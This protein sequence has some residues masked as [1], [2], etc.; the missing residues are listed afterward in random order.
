M[1]SAVTVAVAA[2]ATVA[3]TGCATVDPHDAFADVQSLLA[4]REAA[5]V[6]W[7]LG[8]AADAEAA[9]KVAGLLDTELTA[10]AAV[11]IALLE[12]RRLQ[13]L[14]ERLGVAQ[15][16]LVASGLLR[17]PVF[18][19]EVRFAEGGGSTGFELAVLQPF[20]DVLY[21]PL[22]RRV[23]AA[24]LAA[25]KLRVSGAVLAFAADVR[26]SFYSLQAAL[27]LLELRQTTLRAVEMSH[28]LATRLHAAGNL[29]DLDLTNERVLVEQARLEV[30]L[31][32][33]EVTSWRE[34]CNAAMG[35]WG[36][37]TGWRAFGRLP[38]VPEAEL[39]LAHL[40][41][42]AI[43]RSVELEAQRRDIEQQG[44]RL[45]LE[46]GE[47]L[48]AE[49]GAAAEREAGDGVF[50]A[51]PAVG[52][53][54]PLWNRGQ[55]VAAAGLAE[56]RRREAEYFA[57]A[58]EIRAEVRAAAQ[59]VSAARAREAFHREVLVPLRHRLVAATQL[60]VNAMQVGSFQL[61]EAKRAEIEAGRGYVA[62]LRDYWLARVGLESMLAGQRPRRGEFDVFE[63]SAEP[64]PNRGG[65]GVR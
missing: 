40:E 52:I 8:T 53:T 22:R 13:A 46:R 38:P 41:A 31:A 49:L 57:T 64:S 19:G 2:C 29:R 14:Y 51:G 65:P 62:A 47:A 36:E 24:E 33:T 25:V 55:A 10:D 12:N 63:V 48:L 21:L 39:E 4:D 32:E 17:N 1:S 6:H 56:F 23:A 45:G 34:R 27:Q 58:V 59:A 54:L 20:L 44:E 9:A 7:N 18:E 16:E 3:C 37:R 42:R 11:Q 43:E 30:A 61:L 26:R 60:Q 5:T 50:S 35:L 15:A 28:E